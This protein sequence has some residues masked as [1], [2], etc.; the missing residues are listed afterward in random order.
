MYSDIQSKPKTADSVG[1]QPTYLIV[2]IFPYE[3]KAVAILPLVGH[4]WLKISHDKYDAQ[5][6]KG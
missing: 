1:H 3:A 4:G 5:R 6:D 2:S